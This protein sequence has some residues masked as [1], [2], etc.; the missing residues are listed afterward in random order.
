MESGLVEGQLV[1]RCPQVQHVPLGAAVGMETLEDVLAE[2]R[3]EGRLW[4]VRLAVDRAGPASLLA[5]AA[6]V[7]EQA[8]VSQDLFHGDL[9]AEEREVD[10]GT[11]RAVR[12][13]L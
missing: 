6:Q 10:L 1:H 11:S 12:G 5:T 7:V 8:Q 9:L 4:V 13:R 2:V 3:R